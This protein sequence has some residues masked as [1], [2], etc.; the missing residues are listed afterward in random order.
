MT[1][2]MQAILIGLFSVK[3]T[4]EEA[5]HAANEVLSQH[6]HELAK[7]QREHFGVGDA[8]VRA[9]C[10]PACDFC[11]GVIG[12]ADLIDPEVQSWPLP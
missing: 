6:A 11:R 9:H 4:P 8:P 2:N 12:A 3:H 10:D 1:V 7:Q 5:E